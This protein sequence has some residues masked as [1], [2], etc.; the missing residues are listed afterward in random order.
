MENTNQNTVYA[1][2]EDNWNFINLTNNVKYVKGMIKEVKNHNELFN[3]MTSEK[4]Y[5]KIKVSD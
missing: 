3:L 1:V 5:G 4:G 2:C